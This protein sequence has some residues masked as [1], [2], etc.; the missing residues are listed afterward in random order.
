MITVRL[1][2][3]RSDKT[4]TTR[5]QGVVFDM[6]GLLL[7]SERLYRRLFQELVQEH[8]YQLSDEG[9]RRMVGHRVDIS[10]QVLAEEIG[11]QEPV[12]AI[13]SK[14]KTHYHDHVR[15]NDVPTRPGAREL[16]A[17][18]RERGVPLALCTST[19]RGLTDVK[20][21]KTGLAEAF[22]YS[23]CGDEVSRGKP[24]PEP[25]LKAAAG[26]GIAP[27]TALALEDSPTGLTAAH[28]A[29]LRTI[30]IPDLVQAN[31][32]SL[33]IADAVADSLHCVL[34]WIE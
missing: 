32:E 22:A 21:H 15:H 9:Y 34:G 25:Y 14:L 16:I 19:F 11:V 12:N 8:G 20:L 1:K 27:A 4:H 24:Y 2:H 5:V 30:L 31:D 6:D 29:G 23:V 18:L 3:P 10:K 33:A 13:F 17:A 26:L 28:S 7:D